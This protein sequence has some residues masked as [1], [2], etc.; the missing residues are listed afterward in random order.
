MTDVWVSM[1]EKNIKNKKQLLKKFQV[2]DHIMQQAK[3]NA[4]LCIVFQPIAMKR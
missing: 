2:N 4:I 3:K 1:G